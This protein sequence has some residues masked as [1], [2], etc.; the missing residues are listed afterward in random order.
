MERMS[1]D[2]KPT[3]PALALPRSISAL[4]RPP[5][6]RGFTLIELMIVVVVIGILSTFAIPYFQ[7]AS[8]RARRAEVQVVLEKLNVY[9]INQYESEGSFGTSQFPVGTLSAWNPDPA[10]PIGQ[11]APW[12]TAR[13]GWQAIPFSFEGGLKMRYQ[14]QITAPGSMTITAVGD[15]PGFSGTTTINGL[16]GNYAFLEPIEGA[17]VMTTSEF[18]S[19]F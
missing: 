7:R 16:T 9:F 6:A 12:V 8:A 3:V 10:T 4:R 18:P 11:P 1:A 19:N 13:S 2:S 14:Y 5:A 15:M 17:T